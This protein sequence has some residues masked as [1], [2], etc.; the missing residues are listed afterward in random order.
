MGLDISVFKNLVRQDQESEELWSIYNIDC[1]AERNTKFPSGQYCAER[2]LRFGAGSYGGYNQFRRSLANMLNTT[3]EAIWENAAEWK[4]KPFYEIIDFADNEGSI[5]YEVAENLLSDFIE[6]KEKAEFVL[7]NWEW[8][9]Y[10]DFMAALTLCVE[11]K[12]VM[13]YH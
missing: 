8:E 12:G 11:N 2:I 6:Y 1:F 10:K 9:K 3:P 4:D 13:V 7:S 5:D